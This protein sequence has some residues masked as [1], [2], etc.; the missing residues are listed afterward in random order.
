MFFALRKEV[1]NLI[2]NIGYKIFIY[3]LVNYFFDKYFGY[4][5][6]TWNDF[7]TVALIFVE[8]FFKIKKNRWQIFNLM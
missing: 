1:K 6:W 3:L 5:D 4:T 2:T 8:L 7:I